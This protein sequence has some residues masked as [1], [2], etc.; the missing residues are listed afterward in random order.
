MCKGVSY[1]TLPNVIASFCQV[2]MFEEAESYNLSYCIE[3]GCC[4]YVCP[5]KI[6]LLHWIKYGKSQLKREEQ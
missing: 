5:A 4:A 6:P 1:G 2:D 3:C